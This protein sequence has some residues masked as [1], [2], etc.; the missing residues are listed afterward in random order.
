MHTYHS[1]ATF[2]TLLTLL[3]KYTNSN[4]GW[5]LSLVSPKGVSLILRAMCDSHKVFYGTLGIPPKVENKSHGPLPQITNIISQ[6]TMSRIIV[7]VDSAHTELSRVT[8]FKV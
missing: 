6:P 7:K 4:S 8:C 3:N 5:F 1:T 2:D